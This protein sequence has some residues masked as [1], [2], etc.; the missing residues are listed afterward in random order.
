[1]SF[2]T[3]PPPAASLSERAISV[4]SFS[5]SYGMPGIRLGWLVTRD[6]TLFQ[7][8]LA[9]KEQVVIGGSV[10]DEAIGWEMYRRRP[11]LLPPI[12]AGIAAALATTRRWIAGDDGFEWV[13][14]RGGV[15]GFPRIRPEARVDPERF[16]ARLFEAHGTIVGPG[17][18][19]E[20]GR[21]EFRLGYGWPAPDRLEAG[22]AAL[23]ATLA[24]LR[25]SAGPGR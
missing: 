13:E 8:L 17:P 6:R 9:A 18:W 5:K 3:P 15:V 23:S 2:A 12:R 21:D 19:F 20:R 22:L 7:T 11:E 10:V 24:E 25:G 1:M 16:H 4:S 14:P